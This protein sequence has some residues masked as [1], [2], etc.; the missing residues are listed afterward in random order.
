MEKVANSKKGLFSFAIAMLASLISSVGTNMTHFAIIA[1]VYQETGSATTAGLLA[2]A[3]YGAVIVASIFAG[4]LVDRFNRKMLI[5]ISDVVGLAAILGALFLYSADLLGPWFLVVFGVVTG[6]VGS[7][8]FPAYLSSITAMVPEDQRSRA[9]GMYQTAWSLSSMIS[10]ALAGILLGFVDFGGILVIDAVSFVVIIVMIALLHIPQP[11]PVEEDPNHSLWKDSVDGFRYLWQRASLLGFV[12]VL[13]SFN[14][15]FGAYEGLFR[16]MMLAVTDNNVE[17]AGWALAG[18]G[19]G[20]VVSGVFM[21]I[22]KGPKNR[23]PLTLISWALCGFFGFIVG[24]FGR[25]LLVWLIA[26]FLQGFFN[27]IAVVLTVGIWQSKVEPSYQGRVFSIMKLVAQIT[28]PPA[29]FV[30][31]FI[32]DHFAEPALQEGGALVHTFGGLVG[33]GPG[34]GMSLVL[35][36]A[37]LVFG[38]LFPL[39]MFLIRS[40]R[41]AESEFPSKEVKVETSK[42]VTA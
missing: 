28:I 13:T 18:Y 40:V 4:A 34:A 32:A 30:M 41:E 25:T 16:P 15:A 7:I 8:Q 2:T 17:L 23:V 20:N 26:G 37:G 6:L 21:T 12:L 42:E 27:N 29:V 10:P 9:N 22:W 38:V 14:I 3:T 36:G 39:G 19:I 33:T 31:T 11:E 24:G 35:I 1:W 5:I